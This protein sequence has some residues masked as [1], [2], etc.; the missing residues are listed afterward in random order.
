MND[1]IETAKEIINR[2]PE[3]QKNYAEEIIE[4]ALN[5]EDKLP[6]LL[7]ERRTEWNIKN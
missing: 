6:K 2:M 1:P 4:S 5:Q 7:D 3:W